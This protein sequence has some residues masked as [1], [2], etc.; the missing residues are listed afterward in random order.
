MINLNSHY[1][2]KKTKYLIRN[3]ITES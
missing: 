1:Q 2:Q 3:G